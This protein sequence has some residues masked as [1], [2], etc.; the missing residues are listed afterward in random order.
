MKR[1]SSPS[2]D[3][4][5][6]VPEFPEKSCQNN[7]NPQSKGLSLTHGARAHGSLDSG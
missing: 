7:W 4:P 6:G 5:L 1:S 3:R 2:P